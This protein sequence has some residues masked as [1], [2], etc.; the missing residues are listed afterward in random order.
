MTPQEQRLQNIKAYQRDDSFDHLSNF[1]RHLI[2]CDA[3]FTVNEATET[4]FIRFSNSGGKTETV[5]LP[6]FA[7]EPPVATFDCS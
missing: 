5:A 1:F 7:Y 3:S 4:V 2:R 6:W